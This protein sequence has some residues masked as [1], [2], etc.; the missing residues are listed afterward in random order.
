MYRPNHNEADASPFIML[1][2][3]IILFV[4]FVAICTGCT[5]S[6]SDSVAPEPPSPPPCY[7]ADEPNDSFETPN[8]IVPGADLYLI[9]GNIHHLDLDCV[10]VTG[11]NGAPFGEG[12]VDISWDYAAGWDMEV[13]VSWSAATAWPSP[14]GARMTSGPWVACPPR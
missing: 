10:V 9:E 7:R 4:A 12:L 14:C 8:V 1:A 2:T 11:L 3:T 5:S 13:S 6:S